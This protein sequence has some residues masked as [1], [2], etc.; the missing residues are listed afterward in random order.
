MSRRLKTITS[1]DATLISRPRSTVRR[2]PIRTR[3]LK[4]GRS[5]RRSY[6]KGW[7]A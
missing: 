1:P 2:N 7:V 6:L 3:S 4:V 5:G